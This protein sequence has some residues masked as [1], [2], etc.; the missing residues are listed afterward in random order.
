MLFTPPSKPKAQ[1]C[2]LSGCRFH[3]STLFLQVTYLREVDNGQEYIS[4]VFE[5][6][7]ISF[8]NLFTYFIEKVFNPSSLPFINEKQVIVSKVDFTLALITAVLISIAVEASARF[9]LR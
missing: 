1:L 8:I 5:I 6:H 2:V 7:I 4:S 3:Y 9:D